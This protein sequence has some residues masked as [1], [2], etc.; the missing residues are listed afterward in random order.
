[1]WVVVGVTLGHV[2]SMPLPAGPEVGF[3]AGAGAVEEPVDDRDAVPSQHLRP[4]F[5]TWHNQVQSVRDLS[6]NSKAALRRT[7]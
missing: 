5:R 4:L 1:V 7:L 2:T 3:P 6:G